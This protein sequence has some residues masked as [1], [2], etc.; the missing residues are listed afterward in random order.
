[1]NK[2]NRITYKEFL[3]MVADNSSSARG[4]GAIHRSASSQQPLS[5]SASVP[6]STSQYQQYLA[7]IS[8]ADASVSQSRA[9][10]LKP[11]A[12]ASQQGVALYSEE[13][14]SSPEAPVA[15]NNRRAPKAQPSNQDRRMAFSVNFTDIT[16]SEVAQKVKL[17][18][19]HCVQVRKELIILP[20]NRRPRRVALLAASSKAEK[21]R[22]AWEALHK[23][24][25]NQGENMVQETLAAMRSSVITEANLV[26]VVNELGNRFPVC[27][28]SYDNNNVG[29]GAN[30]VGPMGLTGSPTRKELSADFEQTFAGD[31]S[32]STDSEDD[33][34]D[35]QLLGIASH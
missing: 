28:D 16:E 7:T 11:K 9:P 22:S 13:L 6:R 20:A 5:P 23:L 2:D 18:K 30:S 19:R 15:T 27:D 33:L 17:A 34:G 35:L 3:R 29:S 12:A 8:T 10:S 25:C 32:D 21:F 26:S 14:S 1:L 24:I 31:D 4:T